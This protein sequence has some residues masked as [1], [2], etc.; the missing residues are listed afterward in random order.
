MKKVIRRIKDSRML[1]KFFIELLGMYNIG[2]VNT[3]A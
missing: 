2:R 3:L 1:H